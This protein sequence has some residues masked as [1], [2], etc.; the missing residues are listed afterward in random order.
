[1][2]QRSRT[3]VVLGII[4]GILFIAVVVALTLLLTRPAPTQSA[5]PTDPAPAAPGA[6]QEPEEPAPASEL[7]LAAAGFSLVADDGSTLLDYTW[8]GDA[9]QAVAVLTDAFGAAPTTRVQEGDRTHYPD[10]TVY[11]WDGLLFLDMIEGDGKPRGEYMQPSYVYVLAN[12][13]GD[14]AIVPEFGLAIGLTADEVRT[15][16]PDE[17]W[18]QRDD[19][20]TLEFLFARERSSFE[21]GTY[22]V[23]VDAGRDGAA[24]ATIAYV[25]FTG[26]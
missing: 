5:A 23:I 24:A 18:D 26:M 10:Y 14:V 19:G 8:A 4:A 20:W 9:A 13:V 16:G 12:A 21:D 3:P 25:M 2:A 15:L 6:P 1:M 17:E 11:E 22:S 7:R